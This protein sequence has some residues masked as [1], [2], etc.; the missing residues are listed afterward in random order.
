MLVRLTRAEVQN[1]DHV[2]CILDAN[3]ACWST[4]KQREAQ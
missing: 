1:R 3:K 2:E 4:D